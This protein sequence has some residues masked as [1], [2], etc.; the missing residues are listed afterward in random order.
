M[1]NSFTTSGAKRASFPRKGSISKAAAGRMDFVKICFNARHAFAGRPQSR[2][3]TGFGFVMQRSAMRFEA[4]A[5]KQHPVL[6]G[7]REPVRPQRKG[8]RA[9]DPLR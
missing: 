7:F 2:A 9:V 1:I 3:E 8:G 4:D 5:L 6:S